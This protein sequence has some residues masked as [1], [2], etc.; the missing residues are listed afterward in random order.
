MI[1]IPSKHIALDQ[2]TY[3]LEGNYGAA[4]GQLWGS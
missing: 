4:M 3:G 1:F 2:H